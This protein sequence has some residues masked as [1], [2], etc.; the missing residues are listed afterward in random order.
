MSLELET[1]VPSARIQH[2]GIDATARRLV[3]VRSARDVRL[4][5]DHP[6]WGRSP[7][8]ILGGGSNVLFTRDIDDAVVVKT[9]I[10][11]L[12]VLEDDARSTLIEVGAGE[13]WHDV[14]IWALEQGFAGL[15]N[16]AL[17]P[18]T[19]GAAPVQ[20]IGAYGLEYPT[21]WSRLMWSTSSP[22][23][24]PPCLRHIVGWV[25]ATAF[26]NANSRASRSSPR[27][28]C[29]CPSPGRLCGVC[30]RGAVVAARADLR[31]IAPRCVSGRVRHPNQ[32]TAGPGQAGQRRELFSRTRWS[33]A[34]S[35]MKSWKNIPTS[36]ATRWTTAPTNS[37]QRG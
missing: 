36:S 25:T 4:V 13:P 30:G 16:L 27:F 22:A 28:A 26:S 15:E 29:V 34:P 11:G 21:G 2:F 14:V 19:A 3:R 9:E 23:A 33:I 1:D 17:I 8:F 35:A 37:P 6:E 32:Q 18:G 20:N 10:R 31:P 24:A 7:K 5:V 12:R